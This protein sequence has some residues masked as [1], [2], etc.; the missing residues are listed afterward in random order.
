MRPGQKLSIALG[1]SLLEG[2]GY[3]GLTPTLPTLIVIEKGQPEKG[4]L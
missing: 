3:Q 4:A 1:M 2:L